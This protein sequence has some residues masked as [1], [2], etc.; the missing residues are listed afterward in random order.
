VK[1]QKVNNKVERNRIAPEIMTQVFNKYGF[2]Y[3][4]N[5]GFIKYEPNGVLDT[6]SNGTFVSLMQN[7]EAVYF[8][9]YRGYDDSTFTAL[10]GLLHDLTIGGVGVYY[11]DKIGFKWIVFDAARY[12]KLCEKFDF[13]PDDYQTHPKHNS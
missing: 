8:V 3:D 5:T 2:G 10:M 6:L 4:L 12:S 9:E 13:E 11:C 1:N 7:V